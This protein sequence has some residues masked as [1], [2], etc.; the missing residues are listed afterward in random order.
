MSCAH[1]DPSIA[2]SPDACDECREK[3]SD[4][5]GGR[6]DL[7]RQRIDA[8]HV[9]FLEIAEELDRCDVDPVFL[10]LEMVIDGRLARE[11]SQIFGMI[12]RI[13]DLKF[14]G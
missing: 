3:L 7:E 4:T 13:A 14:K 5:L 9:R 10:V 6:W 11:P 12:A 1:C 2:F 8:L